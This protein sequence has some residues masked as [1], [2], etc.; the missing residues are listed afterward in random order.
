MLVI[1]DLHSDI[2]DQFWLFYGYKYYRLIGQKELL[3]DDSN[4]NTDELKTL[5]YNLFLINPTWKNV[6]SYYN[7]KNKDEN[8]LIKYIEHFSDNLG[9]QM[10]EKDDSEYSSLG[11]DTN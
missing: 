1:K 7:N 4:I 9:N 10:I 2:S 3:D 11:V 6:I 5:A 8:I